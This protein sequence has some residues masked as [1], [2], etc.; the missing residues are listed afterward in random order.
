[1][2]YKFSTVILLAALSLVG[3][4]EKIVDY[5]DFVPETSAPYSIGDY[6]N[7]NGNCGVVFT[8]TENGYS[9]KIVSL[10]EINES[11][12]R[13]SNTI[14]VNTNDEYN[15]MN[16]LLII[17]K[18]GPQYRFDAFAWCTSFGRG[19]YLPAVRE[20]RQIEE[21]L[22]VINRTLV[23]HGFQIISKDEYWSSNEY[24]LDESWAVYIGHNQSFTNKKVSLLL[25]RAV[26]AF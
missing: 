11:W 2:K 22:D 5:Y 3:C 14:R 8:V 19:W 23:N 15:G 12:D 16:N 26:Y 6:Y 7:E 18:Q 13:Y 4:G 10:V 24:D 25:V 21:N 1:M 17:K 20:L 9:G